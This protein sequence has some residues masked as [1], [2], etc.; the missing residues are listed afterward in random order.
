MNVILYKDKTDDDIQD[1][2]DTR[3]KVSIQL[4]NGFFYQH[5]NRARM[6]LILIILN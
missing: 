2:Q 1:I 3:V 6:N 4:S 5:N